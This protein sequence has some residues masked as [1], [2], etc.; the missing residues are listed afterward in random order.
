MSLTLKKD[1]I[2]ILRRRAGQQRKPAAAGHLRQ[3][4]VTRGFQKRGRQIGEHHKGVDVLSRFRAGAGKPG[5][6]NA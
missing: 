1:V 6:G 5:R 2:A 4:R 3:N